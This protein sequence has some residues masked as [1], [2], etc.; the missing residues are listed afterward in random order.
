MGRRTNN[1]TADDHAA[2]SEKKRRLR[3][4]ERV[5]NHYALLPFWNTEEFCYLSLGYLPDTV[6]ESDHG[7][8]R[9]QMRRRE[10]DRRVKRDR[11]VSREAAQALKDRRDILTRSMALGLI[12]DESPPGLVKWATKR[13][14]SVDPDVEI[15]VTP[16]PMTVR[17]ETLAT[18]L[19]GEWVEQS[20]DERIDG[21][22]RAVIS[23]DLRDAVEGL[24]KE[25]ADRVWSAV[26]PDSWKR[27]GAPRGPQKQP[28]RRP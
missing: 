5:Q 23:Q 22:T 6:I 12:T 1:P 10:E 15:A 18:R 9:E 14:I 19:L 17:A 8:L 11:V 3:F 4:T 21:K 2:T 28:R 20:P 25:G 24:N 7:D 26:A 27:A 16:P 13:G